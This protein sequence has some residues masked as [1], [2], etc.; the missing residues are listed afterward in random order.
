MLK[1]VKKNLGSL[2]PVKTI[3]LLLLSFFKIF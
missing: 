1:I 3:L 2:K